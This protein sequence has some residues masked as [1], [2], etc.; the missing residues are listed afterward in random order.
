MTDEESALAQQLWK[1]GKTASEIAQIIGGGMTRNFVLGHAFRNRDKFPMRDPSRGHRRIKPPANLNTLPKPKATEDDIVIKTM[2]RRTAI[3]G[4]WVT[5][6]YVSIL[7]D[8]NGPSFK[9]A[10]NNAELF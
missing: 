7:D 3:Q 2:K 4:K 5:L 10:A 9:S 8:D 6:P 1:K